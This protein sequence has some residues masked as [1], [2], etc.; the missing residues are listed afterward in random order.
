MTGHGEGDRPHEAG[1]LTP[2]AADCD[3]AR[4]EPLE[5]PDSTDGRHVC[6]A[7]RPADADIARTAVLLDLTTPG[8]TLPAVLD[9]LDQ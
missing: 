2:E 7:C 1:P 6:S 4:D 9:E 3:G 5:H 8:L